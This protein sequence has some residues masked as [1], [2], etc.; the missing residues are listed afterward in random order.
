MKYII[1]TLR[2]AYCIP[3]LDSDGEDGGPLPGATDC[4]SPR[5]FVWCDGNGTSSISITRV[6]L[7]VGQVRTFSS[8]P[9]SI[10]IYNME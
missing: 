8:T 7:H 3:M 9:E 5:P 4:F 1:F 10:S 6:L 2:V